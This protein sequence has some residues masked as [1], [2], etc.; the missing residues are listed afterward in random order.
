MV[1]FS[2]T[3]VAGS[4]SCSL[5]PNQH[6]TRTRGFDIDVQTH[7]KIVIDFRPYVPICFRS[8][9]KAG[10][11][12]LKIDHS[13]FK[14]EKAFTSEM[15]F[16]WRTTVVKTI[17][18]TSPLPNPFLFRGGNLC[19]SVPNANIEIEPKAKDKLFCP[20]RW[21]WTITMT[22]VHFKDKKKTTRDDEDLGAR[23]HPTTQ[24]ATMA[25]CCFTNPLLN[26][27]HTV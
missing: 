14:C 25:S 4:W 20:A 7:I 10:N 9:E 12:K 11:L 13:K 18:I 17:F 16:S 26:N 27:G 24:D 6:E 15:E 22:P 19:Q 23:R 5:F 1:G 8:D 2:H 3:I 21:R